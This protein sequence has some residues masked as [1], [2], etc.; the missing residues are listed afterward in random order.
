MINS[1]FDVPNGHTI[2]QGGLVHAF[3]QAFIFNQQYPM[4]YSICGQVSHWVDWL[5]QHSQSFL[6]SEGGNGA[7][8]LGFKLS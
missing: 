6:V 1:D 4:T 3:C 5:F 8:F 7:G 2:Q